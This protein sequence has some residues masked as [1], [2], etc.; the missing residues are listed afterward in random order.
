MQN[1]VSKHWR[2]SPVPSSFRC[3]LFRFLSLARRRAKAT[4][5]R[6]A[7]ILE[8][9]EVCCE[10]ALEDGRTTTVTSASFWSWPRYKN[11]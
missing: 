7:A 10:A 11:S 3:A 4:S 8:G 1:A 9:W 5:L 6:S 2:V